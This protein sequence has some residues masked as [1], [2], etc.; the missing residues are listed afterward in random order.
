MK[1]YE[2]YSID[3]ETYTLE[4]DYLYYWDNGDYNTPPEDDLTIN[5]VTLNGNDITDFYWD[6]LA[7][8]IDEDVLNHAI[9]N[10]NN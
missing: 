7:D 8:T 6:F 5:K 3:Q 10:K 4:I 1:I 2:T 9:E